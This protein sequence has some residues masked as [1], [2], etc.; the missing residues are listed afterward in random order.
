MAPENVKTPKTL[1]IRSPPSENRNKEENRKERKNE[2][3]IR[4]QKTTDEVLLLCGNWG[5]III[6]TEIYPTVTRNRGNSAFCTVI[7]FT[8][9]GDYEFL[10]NVL[11]G[12]GKCVFSR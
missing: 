10:G 3:R 7:G 11:H 12:I 5:F 1:N 4:N 2:R 8:V 6:I 9:A